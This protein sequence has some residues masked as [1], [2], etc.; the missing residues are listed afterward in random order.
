[1]F[2]V[3][4]QSGLG[5]GLR[6]KVRMRVVVKEIWPLVTRS[7]QPRQQQDHTDEAAEAKLLPIGWNVNSLTVDVACS[8]LCS[9]CIGP[10]WW[11][12]LEGYLYVFKRVRL[13]EYLHKCDKLCVTVGC[14]LPSSYIY[15]VLHVLGCVVPY[16]STQL[17][18]QPTDATDVPKLLPFSYFHWTVLLHFSTSL[19]CNCIH[20]S[21]S[22][23]IP[24]HLSIS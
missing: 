11:Q 1:M 8:I 5:L 3:W 17:A 19:Y 18:F 7:C 12:C 16:T 15:N 10:L 23:N 4:S 9:S 22:L 13:C 2:G 21:D 24:Y 20:T 6:I 14:F